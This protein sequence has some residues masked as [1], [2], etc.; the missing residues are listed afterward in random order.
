MLLCAVGEYFILITITVIQNG[1]VCLGIHIL[2]SL[3]NKLWSGWS[4]SL[5]S[6][7][8]NGEKC[9]VLEVNLKQVD[10][11][12]GGHIEEKWA[13]SVSLIAYSSTP[14]VYVTTNSQALITKWKEWLP[15]ERE[16]IFWSCIW[17]FQLLLVMICHI[18][19]KRLFWSR[20]NMA[21]LLR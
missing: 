13:A 3:E 10:G 16:M 20:I 14:P 1:I 8:A 2:H 15:I 11:A 12:A 4:L 18:T 19:I 7:W 21:A 5:E 17:N 9:C 6:T